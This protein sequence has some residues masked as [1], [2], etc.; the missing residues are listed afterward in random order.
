MGSPDSQHGLL[1][2][3]ERASWGTFPDLIR[4][5]DLRAMEKEPEYLAA[6][7]GDWKAAITLARRLVT[8]ET[9]EAVKRLCAAQPD[10]RIVP[11]MAQEAGGRN[12][13]PLA[14]A[15]VLGE[16]LGVSV[17]YGIT[18]QEQVF[19]TNASADHR[20]AFSPSYTGEVTPGRA[21][22]IVDDTVTVG[23]TVAALRGHLENR[24]GLVVGAATMTAHEGAVRLPVK[25]AMVD[26]IAAKHGAAMNEYWKQEFGY[27]IDLLTQGEAGH[28]RA[29]A[30]VDAIRDRIAAARDAAGWKADEGL[31]EPTATQDEGQALTLPSVA[32]YRTGKLERIER[33]YAHALHSFWN[34]GDT[35]PS[36]RV[37][38]EQRAPT[39]GHSPHE[40]LEAFWDHADYR[41]LAIATQAAV[42]RSTDASIRHASLRHSL[43]QLS[44]QRRAVNDNLPLAAALASSPDQQD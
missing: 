22:F 40:A 28:L 43:R 6:K 21:Y 7:A 30:S 15:E 1:P 20:L 31:A 2:R 35:L 18:Q 16:V 10:L 26:A 39:H 13:I 25:Q 4:N 11:V 37:Q 33:A 29:A 3:S 41:D 19:R 8:D 12:K 36:L 5:A 42:A 32:S 34:T 38:I 14:F 27:D 44:K 24:G 9:I 17:E 23:G